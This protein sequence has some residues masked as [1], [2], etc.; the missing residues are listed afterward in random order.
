METSQPGYRVRPVTWVFWSCGQAAALLV[1]DYVY[2][3]TMRWVEL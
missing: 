1:R 3:L 2:L